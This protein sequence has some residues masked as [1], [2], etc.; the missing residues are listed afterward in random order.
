VLAVVNIGR[1]CPDAW[2][3]RN[4]RLAYDQVVTTV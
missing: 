2:F 4:P 3:Q 1:P